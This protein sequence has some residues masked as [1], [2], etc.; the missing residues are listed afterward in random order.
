M[1]EQQSQGGKHIGG[2]FHQRNT[3]DGHHVRCGIV[4]TAFHFQ[5]R[6]GIVLEVQPFGTEDGEHRRCVGGSDDRAQEEAQ[7]PLD[8]QGEVNEEP[9]QDRGAHDAET[10]E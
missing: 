7:N 8:A 2:A 6:G 10:G 4:T 1:R 9:G 5:E 3:N